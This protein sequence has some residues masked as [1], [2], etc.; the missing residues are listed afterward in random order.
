MKSIALAFA[1]GIGQVTLVAYQTRQILAGVG[2]VRLFLVGFAISATWVLNV[3][4]AISGVGPGAAYA[5]GA[6]CGSVLAMKIR[7]G[8]K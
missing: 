1:T 5:L 8:K 3:H 2:L 7:L 4:A 6:G